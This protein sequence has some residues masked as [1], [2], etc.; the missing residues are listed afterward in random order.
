[1][2][3]FTAVLI[4]SAAF[5]LSAAPLASAAELEWNQERVAGLA[6]DLI[7]PIETLRAELESRPSVP[8]KEEA[9]AAV[10][11]DLERVH[12]RVKELAERLANGEG[13]AKTAALFH[14]VETSWKQATKRSRDYPARFDMHVHIDRVQ[15]AMSQLARYYRESPS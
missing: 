14:D 10:M 9:R 15:T 1:M 3:F 13:S 6:L 11:N 8:E 12:L 4:S 5:V 7:Q 2:R